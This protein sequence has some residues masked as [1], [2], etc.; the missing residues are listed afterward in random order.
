MDTQWALIVANVALVVTNISVVKIAFLHYRRVGK[1]LEQTDK[2][3]RESQREF[4]KSVQAQRRNQAESDVTQ[5]HI[6]KAELLIMPDAQRKEGEW[7]EAIKEIEDRLKQYSNHR[8]P[9]T[10]EKIRELK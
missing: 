8:I 4:A 5:L 9:D 6:K 2:H 3:F 7:G 1:Q 10:E